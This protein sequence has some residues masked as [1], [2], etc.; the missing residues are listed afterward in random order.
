[1]LCWPGGYEFFNLY[2]SWKVSISSSVLKETLLDIGVWA[3]NCFLLEFGISQLSPSLIILS[4]LRSKQWA[5]WLASKCDL[6]F[7]LAALSVLTLFSMIGILIYDESWSN[8]VLIFSVWG[9]VYLLHVDV[10]HFEYGESFVITSL[11]MFLIALACI[12]T[13]S[14]ILLILR[15]ILLMLFQ[16]SC[17]LWFYLYFFTFS[18][19]WVFKFICPLYK[20]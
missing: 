6:C 15:F 2:L 17:I 16:R 12:S 19:Q 7:S 1:M 4:E 18:A 13:F 14:Y 10:C 5:Y 20:A 8:F 11:K 9:P 3:G